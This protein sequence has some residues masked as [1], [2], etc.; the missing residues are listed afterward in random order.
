MDEPTVSRSAVTHD[1]RATDRR[2]R[3]QEFSAFYRTSVGDVVTFLLWQGAS[4]TDAV[5]VAQEAMMAAYAHWDTIQH[6]RAWIRRVASRAWGH[7]FAR[8]RERP[9]EHVPEN[10]SLLRD[11]AA[12][13]SIGQRH[14]V[15]AALKTLPLR[16][17]QVMAWTI[18]GFTP[19]EI[20][21]EL[22][23]SLIHI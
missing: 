1:D 17:R 16:Q 2:Q 21:T 3:D 6:H 5:D 22:G 19:A 18:D 10:S 14:A 4:P 15:L 11:D 12:I 20:A 23:L 8:V 9:T 7:R 13:E